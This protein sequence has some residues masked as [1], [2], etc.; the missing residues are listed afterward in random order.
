MQQFAFIPEEAAKEG[1]SSL[2]VLGAS[3]D[4]S[5]AGSGG[6]LGCLRVLTSSLQQ[7]LQPSAAHGQN[8]KHRLEQTVYLRSAHKGADTERI[9]DC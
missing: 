4:M 9:L 3:A 8:C 2:L 7:L 1:V 6:V 5:H